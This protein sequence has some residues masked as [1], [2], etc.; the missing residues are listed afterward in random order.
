M[1]VR[2]LACVNPG[3]VV[4]AVPKGFRNVHFLG[5][6]RTRRNNYLQLEANGKTASYLAR[7]LESLK[8]YRP[9]R[10]VE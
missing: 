3:D 1:R 4:E 5:T 10:V 8:V 9:D 2:N 6:V 7:D